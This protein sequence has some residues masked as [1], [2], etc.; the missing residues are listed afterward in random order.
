MVFLLITMSIILLTLIITLKS[1]QILFFLIP[2]PL[3]K[4][5]LRKLHRCAPSKHN[6]ESIGIVPVLVD[7]LPFPMMLIAHHLNE[8]QIY[9]VVQFLFR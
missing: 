5:R 9:Y 8:V 3:I 4:D 1:F 2:C 7:V 6:E